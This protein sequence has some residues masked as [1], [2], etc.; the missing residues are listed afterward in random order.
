MSILD[1]LGVIASGGL[2]SVAGSA[3]ALIGTQLTKREERKSLEIRMQ[4]ETKLRE[5]EAQEIASENAHALA[6]ADKKI[7][8]TENEGQIAQDIEETKAFKQ[9]LKAQLIGTGSALVDGIRGIMRPLI[10]MYMLIVMSLM[11][12]YIFQ[13]TGLFDA[14]PMGAMIELNQKIVNQILFLTATTVT[15][16]F[17]SRPSSIRK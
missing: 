13:V 16:W 6:M 17:G 14:Y 11:S 10:T 8:Q 9:S 1:G 3:I 5:V 2:S 15:W 4:H 12:F 7:Q